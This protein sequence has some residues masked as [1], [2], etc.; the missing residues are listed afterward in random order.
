[1]SVNKV[2]LLGNVGQDP[3]VKQFSY[4]KGGQ[5]Q[6]ATSETYTSKN[7]EKVTTTEWTNISV[8]GPLAEIVE[9]YVHKGSKLYLEGKLQSRKWTD[10]NNVE[11]TITEVVAQ[12]IQLLDSKQSDTANK[13]REAITEEA[14]D[15]TNDLPF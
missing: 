5:F 10:Q 9:K 4:N 2:I 1:M 12:S 11:R 3:I 7:G 6:L 15:P 8:W 13:V 14:D